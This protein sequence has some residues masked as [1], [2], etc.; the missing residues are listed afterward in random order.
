MVADLLDLGEEVARDENRHPA[1]RNGEQKVAH[2]GDPRGVQAI[3][4]FVEHE[5]RR[6]GQQRRCDAEPL[7]HAVRVLP[8]GVAGPIGEV[9]EREHLFHATAR[10]LTEARER[11]EVRPS[12]QRRVEGGTLDHR[13]DAREEALW[14]RERLAE[15][16]A[17]PGTRPDETEEHAHRRRLAGAVRTDEAGDG[18][19]GDG[20]ID[21]VDGYE[22]AEVLR[23]RLGL[24]REIAHQLITLV[25]RAPRRSRSASVQGA[26]PSRRA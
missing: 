3:R 2:P 5:E 20:E 19:L 15:H 16:R 8:H 12:R 10:D 14:R 17:S 18:P 23:Q 22:R 6:I 1:G 24:D 11:A 7:S 26:P 21:P 4:R 9:H 13:P 25:R